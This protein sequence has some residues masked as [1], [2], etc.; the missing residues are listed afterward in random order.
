MQGGGGGEGGCEDTAV[1]LKEAYEA[2]RP[3]PQKWRTTVGRGGTRA[4]SFVL[5]KCD[6]NVSEED[7]KV[8]AGKAG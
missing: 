5:M 2:S 8:G 3:G 6:E 4:A 1:A 7:A